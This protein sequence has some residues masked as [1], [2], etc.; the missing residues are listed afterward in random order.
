[1]VNENPVLPRQI[2]TDGS[3]VT[4]L[5]FGLT[6]SGIL[7]AVLLLLSSVYLYDFLDGAKEKAALDE[8]SRLTAAAEQLSMRG[9]GSE[10]SLEL[11]LPEGVSVD[12]GALPGRQDKWPEDA[13]D[14]CVRTGEKSTFYYSDASFSNSELE[15]PVSLVSGRHRLLLSTELEPKSGRLFVL[16]SEKDALKNI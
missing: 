5:P 14:Y 4:S 6:V 13:N 10:I 1:M 9:E 2:G 3:A 12:F 11:R 8:I 7:F 16:I 15:G